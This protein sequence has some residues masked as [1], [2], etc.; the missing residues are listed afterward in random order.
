MNPTGN[1]EIYHDRSYSITGDIP[2]NLREYLHIKVEPSIEYQH[3]SLVKHDSA[4]ISLLKEHDPELAG[5]LEDLLN[6]WVA[7]IASEAKCHKQK[8]FQ[9]RKAYLKEE[10]KVIE[11]YR[12]S[13][14]YPDIHYKGKWFDE[15]PYSGCFIDED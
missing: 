1:I 14:N 9:L 6:L 15:S 8:Q 2:D 10:D 13:V 5:E 12:L 4:A 11:N 7:R 3:C